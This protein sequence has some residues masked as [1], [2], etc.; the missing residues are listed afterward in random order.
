MDWIPQL[1]LVDEYMVKAKY[2]SV[3]L[4][5]LSLTAPCSICEFY[6]GVISTFKKMYDFY[7]LTNDREQSLHFITQIISLILIL[8]K[9]DIC[10]KFMGRTCQKCTS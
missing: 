6:E 7:L 3:R 10:L 2:D 9:Y 5:H 1:A 8:L 4:N